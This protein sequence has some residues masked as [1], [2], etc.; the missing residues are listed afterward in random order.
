MEF[1]C[2]RVL[3]DA[4]SALVVTCTCDF[5]MVLLL[6]LSQLRSRLVVRSTTAPLWWMSVKQDSRITVIT[7]SGGNS[8]SPTK[9]CWSRTQWLHFSVTWGDDS[10]HNTVRFSLDGSVLYQA[11]LPHSTDA[12]E[13]YF[14]PNFV[15][16]SAFILSRGLGDDEIQT[17]TRS[18][19]LWSLELWRDDSLLCLCSTGAKLVD[20]LDTVQVSHY[21][22]LRCECLLYINCIVSDLF[23]VIV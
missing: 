8:F 23:T 12:F 6:C 18:L 15:T 22:E 7:R 3:P 11:L 10:P 9:G 13:I 17:I 21:R 1:H 14:T 5:H 20:C 2:A 19:Q 16:D 4:C